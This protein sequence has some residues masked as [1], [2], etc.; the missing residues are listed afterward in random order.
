MDALFDL[1][2]DDLSLFLEE[3]AEEPKKFPMQSPVLLPKY[4]SKPDTS[5]KVVLKRKYENDDIEEGEIVE[6][7][8]SGFYF[9][10]GVMKKVQGCIDCNMG[11][12]CRNR[13]NITTEHT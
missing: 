13:Q 5:S 2:D 11:R 8:C 4:F 12:T 3:P 1:H 9:D 10:I 6:T 7:V